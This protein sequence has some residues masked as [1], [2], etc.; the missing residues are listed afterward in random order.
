MPT[1]L[2]RGLG[3]AVL[4]AAAIT[5]VAKIAVFQPTES[6]TTTI[7]IVALLVGAA[8][9]WSAIDAWLRRRDRGRTW[10]IAGLL[11]GPVSGVLGVIGKALF[12]DQ[13]GIA[14]LWPAVTGGAA[15]SALLVLVPAGL[16]LFVGSRLHPPA[17][18]APV[19]EQDAAEPAHRPSGEP[20]G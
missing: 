10:F 14:Q 18:D 15:M 4:H 5:A 20:T 11:T 17:G 19:D 8:A 3:M 16:G 2:L 7:V 13:T 12:V 1:W 9:L 6:T